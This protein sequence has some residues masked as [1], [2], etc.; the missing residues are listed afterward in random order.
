M[1]ARCLVVVLDVQGSSAE[2]QTVVE[3]VVVVLCPQLQIVLGQ[4]AG[5]EELVERWWFGV[6]LRPLQVEQ[7]YELRPRERRVLQVIGVI[8]RMV[9]HRYTLALG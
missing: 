8:G 9:Q 7:F 5:V 2:L 6:P 3:V 4:R 1:C